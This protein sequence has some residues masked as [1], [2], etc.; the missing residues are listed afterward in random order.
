MK[1]VNC[2]LKIVIAINI[3]CVSLSF[4]CGCLDESYFLSYWGIAPDNISQKEKFLDDTARTHDLRYKPLKYDKLFAKILL[5]A[6]NTGVSSQL[7]EGTLIEYN[8]IYHARNIPEYQEL[9][10]LLPNKFWETNCSEQKFQNTYIVVAESGAYLRAE[11]NKNGKIIK[12]VN[13]GQLVE[14]LGTSGDWIHN[15]SLWGK[16]YIHKSLLTKY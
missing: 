15:E 6:K 14:V 11:P 12:V 10:T 7:I 13:G 4:A 5:D 16:G 8:C 9:K 1:I 2:V 3:L